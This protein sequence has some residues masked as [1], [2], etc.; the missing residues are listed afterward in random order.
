[1]HMQDTTINPAP[2]FPVS[3]NVARTIDRIE[4]TARVA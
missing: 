4:P 3:L 1:M 2:R